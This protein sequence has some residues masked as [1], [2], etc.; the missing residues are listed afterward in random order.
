MSADFVGKYDLVASE[1]FD[2]FLQ[3]LGVNWILRKTANALKPSVELVDN[4]DGTWT[5]KTVSTFKS[6]DIK[7]KL[8]EEFDE[9]RM[10][11][12]KVKSII[13]LD[14][15]KLVQKQ[16]S[17]PPCEIIREFNGAEMKTI[18]SCKGV[19]STRTYKKI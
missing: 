12:T 17:E 19:T 9:T 18:C 1:N 6:T 16:T 14:G 4:S 11:G 13:S 15:N 2:E 7:F 8:D 5:W 3:A 10:D